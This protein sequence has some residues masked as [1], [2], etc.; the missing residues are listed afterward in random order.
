MSNTPAITSF[1]EL[2]LAQPILKAIT[3]NGYESPSP[4]QA[5]SIPALL[6]GRDVLGQAQT[7]TGKTAAFA[8]PILS[9][10]DLSAKGVQ[11]LVLTPTRELAIQVAEAFQSYAKYLSG[12][13]VLPIYGGQSFEPQLKAL[14]RGVHVVV[15]TPGR[16]M[17][18][19]RRKTLKLDRLSTLVL[20]EADEMLRMGF[21]DDVD[22]ILGHTPEQRQIALYSATMPKQVKKVAVDHLTDPLDIKI[23]TKTSTAKNINQR[24]WLV[25]GLHK[26][27]ALTRLL[28]TEDFDGVLIFVRTKVATEE[29]ADK[30]KARGFAAE[31]LNGDLVQKQRERLVNHL[32]NGHVDILIGTDVVARGLDVDRISHVINYHIPYDAESYVHRIGRTGRAGRSGEAILFVARREQRML[33][34]I[35]NTTK[36]KIEPMKM[37][38]VKDINVQRMQKFKDRISDTLASADLGIYQ[39]IVREFQQETDNDQT[40]IAAALAFM[41]QGD[42]GLMLSE[43]PAFYD[44][45]KQGNK[46]QKPKSFNDERSKNRKKLTLDTEPE[47]LKKH[48]D[49]AMQRYFMDV[50][51]NNDVK[52]S[53]IVGMIINEAD[54][55]K[56]YIGH[57]EIYDGCSTVDLPADMPDDLLKQLNKSFICG[58]RSGMTE[59]QKDHSIEIAEKTNNDSNYRGKKSR[60]GKNKKK[61]DFKGAKRSKSFSSDKD[62]KS[63]HRKKPRS[64]K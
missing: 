51:Y 36:Q 13:H 4:I 26:L 6:S 60:S 63:Q 17:D 10:L 48:P 23:A 18:H 39:Q 22:W 58:K 56:E 32:K 42:K 34:M 47:P 40:Q 3:D 20:D 55:N 15:G 53:N 28:E 16:I 2:G 5:K 12:F 7:G 9:Q 25:S 59:L 37:P 41:A 61:G 46:R 14:R 29:L 35:E 24:Y 54:L 49:V 21:I 38:T 27:D 19:M 1:D 62:R 8:L 11:V 45:E 50:G 33:R 43:E 52:P 44:H 31:A 30:L 57:I 64:K